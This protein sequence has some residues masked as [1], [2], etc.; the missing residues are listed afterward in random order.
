M[1]NHKLC[2][3]TLKC[4]LGFP[5]GCV[6]VDWE[7]SGSK[8]RKLWKKKSQ[9]GQKERRFFFLCVWKLL[10]VAVAVVVFASAVLSAP[11][12]Q[13]SDVFEQPS[14]AGPKKIEFHISLPEV[15][16]AEESKGT[17]LTSYICSVLTIPETFNQFRRSHIQNSRRRGSFQ[18]FAFLQL[19]KTAKS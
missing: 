10:S 14:P 2:F 3:P 8:Q 12:L 9:S 15:A 13:P 1:S 11:A 4:V 6:F 5:P 16:T 18:S 17:S 19:K 7:I